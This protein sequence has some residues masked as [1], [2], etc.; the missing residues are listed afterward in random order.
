MSKVGDAWDAN[1]ANH[2]ASEIA[3]QLGIVLCKLEVPGRR[4]D[5]E[6]RCPGLDL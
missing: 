6:A 1:H 2:L 3:H 5:D 4:Y